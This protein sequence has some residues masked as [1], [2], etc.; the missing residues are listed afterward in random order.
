[1]NSN[2]FI[3][4][5]KL[6]E[7][8]TS[9]ASDNIK[10]YISELAA[11]AQHRELNN[12]VRKVAEDAVKE[13]KKKY[14]KIT[15]NKPTDNNVPKVH[16]RSHTPEE[17]IIFA[18]SI[19]DTYYSMY[20]ELCGKF[21]VFKHITTWMYWDIEK[22]YNFV[23]T[24]NVTDT[25]IAI[26]AN[27]NSNRKI[28]FHSKL[29]NDIHICLGF[30]MEFA[31]SHE[32]THYKAPGKGPHINVAVLIPHEYA[33]KSRVTLDDISHRFNLSCDK[34]G[35]QIDR[36][37]IFKRHL[38]DGEVYDM[39]VDT[40]MK[41]VTELL[42]NISTVQLVENTGNIYLNILNIFMH[43]T[44][45]IEIFTTPLDEPKKPAVNVVQ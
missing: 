29:Y 7:E 9:N 28:F 3:E 1:M 5:L 39:A 8:A 10:A 2:E 27:E 37:D 38:E 33:N 26:Y 15:D 42:S 24:Y 36:F 20:N 23:E 21:P 6:F 32:F 43:F 16:A 19:C 11:T 30:D 13:A 35:V 12:K 18:N 41:F 34:F 17:K 31:F 44:E 4:I 45:C 40:N 22:V 14:P 25:P